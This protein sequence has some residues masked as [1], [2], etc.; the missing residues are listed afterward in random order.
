[1]AKGHGSKT[2]AE[3]GAVIRHWT[4]AST[5]ESVGFPSAAGLSSTEVG[6]NVCRPT[7]FSGQF[8]KLGIKVRNRNPNQKPTP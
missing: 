2:R 5:N 4:L 1:M 8:G 7:R 6:S 3:Q